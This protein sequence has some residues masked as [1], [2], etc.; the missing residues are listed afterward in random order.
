MDRGLP[1]IG[2][3]WPAALA[4]LAP[5]AGLLAGCAGGASAGGDW[6]AERT[7]VG[8]VE[9]VR[10]LAGSV[11]GAPVTLVEELAIGVLD[12]DDEYLFGRIDHVAA[13]GA[14]GVYVFDGQVPALRH[15]G[16]DGRYTR[17][18]GG[19]GSGPGEHGDAALGLAVLAD[20]RV[21]LRDPR[22]GRF[23]IYGPDGSALDHWPLASG[24][25]TSR[26]TYVDT[27]GRI[28]AR[29]LTGPLE[30]DAP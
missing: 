6:E 2:L 1:K 11:W 3:H 14:G 24:L 17:R 10:T 21:L 13:D 26:A 28:Y 16:P 9:V 22:N 12:G 27:A 23:N 30:R 4:T 25:F 20:G 18:L 29:I 15:Y 5:L 19:V 7:T 8:G